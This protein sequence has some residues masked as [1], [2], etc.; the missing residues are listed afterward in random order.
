M[1]ARWALWPWLAVG[2][3]VLSF[4]WWH[5]ARTPHPPPPDGGVA[6]VAF[7]LAGRPGQITL[8]R[9]LTPADFDRLGTAP[10]DD[11]DIDGG[12]R[13]VFADA[14]TVFALVPTERAVL[15]VP[16]AHVAGL[17][18]VA[19]DGSDALLLLTA[20]SLSGY[21]GGAVQSLLPFPAG[22]PISRIAGSVDRRRVYLYGSAA[23]DGTFAHR[24]VEISA[25]GTVRSLVEVDEPVTAVTDVAGSL[26]FATMH[27][28]YRWHDAHLQVVIRLPSAV[29]VRSIAAAP[30]V[31]YF[32][33]DDEVYALKGLVAVSIVRRLGGAVRSYR[34][35]LYVLDAR[36]KCLVQLNGM[37]YL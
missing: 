28:I 5:S 3:T 4:A 34:G 1:S 27:A 17:R 16:L 31:L 23:L 6:N 10:S 14:G 36:R 24:V 8:R 29:R 20:S 12:G 18:G 13:V 33:T 26:Y 35:S 7:S 25:D 15:A 2:V 9:I 22:A 37:Q 19:V 21:R 11:F 30:G 32:S